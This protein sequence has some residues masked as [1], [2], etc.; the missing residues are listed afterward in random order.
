MKALRPDARELLRSPVL[1]GVLRAY[2]KPLPT[3]QVAKRLG[4]EGLRSL[5]M[6]LQQMRDP[7]SSRGQQYPLGCCLSILVCAVL[8][9]CRGVRECGEFAA[10]LSTTHRRALRGWRNPRTGQYEMA[11][12]VTLWRML[13]DIDAAELERTVNQWFREEKRLPEVVAI[14]GKALRATLNNEEG[15]NC[16]VS[17]A[18]HPGTPLFSLRLSPLRKARRSTPSKG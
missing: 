7:R 17:A 14:D 9:G 11:K 10:T 4:F 13:R 8:A 2:E 18:S 5:F 12:H 1:P 3:K 16:A 6:V 15:P